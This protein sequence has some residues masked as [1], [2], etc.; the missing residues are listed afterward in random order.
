M[1]TRHIIPVLTACLMFGGACTQKTDNTLTSD[2]FGP[3]RLG[4]VIS[5]LPESVEDLYD[6]IEE[7]TVEDYDMTYIQYFLM[8]GTE[9]VAMLVEYI[10]KVQDIRVISSRIR[11][12]S[13]L[14]T[15]STVEEILAAGGKA[16]CTNAGYWGLV[17]DGLLFEGMELTESGLKKEEDAYLLGTDQDF[18]IEDYVPGTH[19]TDIMVGKYYSEA[20]I[21]IEQKQER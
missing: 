8:N 20:W 4:S 19:P 14:S 6:R 9:P 3:V 2:G 11:T 10:G 1:K 12:A 7:E 18:A 15:A 21:N 17:C 13:G 5:K 16:L